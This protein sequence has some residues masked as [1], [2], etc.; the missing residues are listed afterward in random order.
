MFMGLGMVW[1]SL[2]F[3]IFMVIIV[4]LGG[5]NYLQWKW[6]AKHQ[7]ELDACDARLAACEQFNK[8]TEKGQKAQFQYQLDQQELLK[9]YYE[10]LP[11]RKTDSDDEGK[12]E[13]NLGPGNGG[14]VG[15][16]RPV[17]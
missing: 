13:G 17:R 7:A 2:R 14:D 10:N 4:V 1:N 6:S 11:K 15:K 12:P 5:G 16:L 8:A 9:K 3:L